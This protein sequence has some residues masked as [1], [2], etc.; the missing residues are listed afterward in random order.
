MNLHRKGFLVLALLLTVAGPRV[1]GQDKAYAEP[2][3][4]VVPLPGHR[5]A[6]QY[7]G[8]EVLA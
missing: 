4:R 1:E 7:D 5:V 2:R 8:R 6:F 3:C